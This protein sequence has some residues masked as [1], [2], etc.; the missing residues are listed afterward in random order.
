MTC[1]LVVE[2]RIQSLVAPEM[3]VCLAGMAQILLMEG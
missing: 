3:I 2:G 1:C